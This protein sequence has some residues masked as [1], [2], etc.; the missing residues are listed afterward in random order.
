MQLLRPHRFQKPIM[1]PRD[2]ANV[3]VLL[4][5]L[6]SLY[7]GSVLS[8]KCKMLICHWFRKLCSQ[9]RHDHGAPDMV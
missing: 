3:D 8:K 4:E 7:R 1:G 2:G 9:E 5:V 6:R